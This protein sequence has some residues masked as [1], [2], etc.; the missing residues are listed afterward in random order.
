MTK[1]GIKRTNKSNIA[2]LILQNRSITKAEVASE[3]GLSM[4]TVLSNVKELI[5]SGIVEAIGEHESTGGRKAKALAI[6]ADVKYAAGMD[7]TQDY[8]SFVMID[9]HG[10]IVDKHRVRMDFQHSNHYY[11]TLAE[12]FEIFLKHA[13]V[14]DED[15]LGI[16]VSLPGIVDREGKVLLKSHLFN[17]TNVNLQ[18]LAKRMRFDMVFENDANSAILAENL[19]GNQNI[20]FLALK[21][22]VGGAFYSNGE[23]YSGDHFRGGEFGHII[24]DPNGKDCFCGKQ[25]CMNCYCSARVLS[26]YTNG[27]LDLFFAKLEAKDDIALKL[28][29]EYTEYLAI[30][31]ANL[32]MALDCDIII[33]GDVGAYFDKYM[34]D[35]SEK[36]TRYNAFENDILYVKTCQYKRES[37]AVGIALT[38]VDRYFDTLA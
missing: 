10:S 36:V 24:L 22:T 5:D 4:P 31:V 25:G 7:I 14:K 27:N 35:F 26:K 13:K 21:Q 8:V 28:W 38:F 34:D 1:K 16:G 23:I 3:L 37:S 19:Q 6:R 17:L 9:V 30:A 2:K 15:F 20:V 18:A 33:G 29:D 11:E 32:R 12:E